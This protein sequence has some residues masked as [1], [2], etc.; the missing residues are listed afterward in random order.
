MERASCSGKARIPKEY[1]EE[2]KPTDRIAGKPPADAGQGRSAD[3][4]L[5]YE[6]RVA[7][8]GERH[9]QAKLWNGRDYRTVL[10]QRVPAPKA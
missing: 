7:K 2:V 1:R 4:T 5:I 9:F 8:D 6:W 10:D 3:G